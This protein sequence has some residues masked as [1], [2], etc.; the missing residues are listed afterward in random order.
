[1]PPGKASVLRT[2]EELGY[3]QIDTISV[4]ERA[5]HHTLW[6]R[7][8]TYKQN[9]LDELLAVDRTVF[10]YWGHAASYLPMKDYRFYLPR[11]KSYF[12][13]KSKWERERYEKVSHMLQPV[14]ERVRQEGPLTSK[15]FEPPPGE[16]REGWWDWK[17]AKIALELLFWRGELMIAERR[18]F[19]KVYDLT[20]RVLPAEVD[21]TVPTD[22]ELGEFLVR[23]ALRAYG[24]ASASEINGHLRAADRPVISRA[25]EAM[26]EGG[27][28]VEIELGEI[29]NQPYYSLADT[30]KLSPRISKRVSLL[31][32]FDNLVINRD[33]ISKLFS[34]DY[35]LECYVPAAKRRHGYFVLPIL[36][37]TQ[38]VGRL[39]PKA[40]RKR[41]ELIIHNLYF[42]PGF[43]ADRQFLAKLAA[44][45]AD[46]AK[47]NQCETIK[48]ARV[49]P[50]QLKVP[51][52]QSIEEALCN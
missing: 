49:T 39:D 2:I 5:H 35:V 16:R 25:L 13:P 19:Q 44:R 22:E 46:L 10:E 14:L 47:F 1:L 41:K 34:F 15:A 17:P 9:M 8:P 40:D 18:N 42:E 27:E 7:L 4:I 26:L 45:I 20:E 31:S 51:L 33:R 36:W 50:K 24:L 3:I 52:K 29:G 21:V 30:L 37:G 32:P 43:D 48:L 28:V 6:T 23:R 12:D 11:M 38:F